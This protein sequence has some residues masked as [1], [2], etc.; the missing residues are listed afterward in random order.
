MPD[1]SHKMIEGARRGGGHA[2]LQPRACICGT[3][4]TA[5]R[6]IMERTGWAKARDMWAVITFRCQLQFL[7][8]V[9]RV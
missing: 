5:A 8:S 9:L 6:A 2:L 1:D 4:A 3:K 7:T